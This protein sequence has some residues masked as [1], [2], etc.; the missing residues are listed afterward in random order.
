MGGANGG[1]EKSVVCSRSCLVGVEGLRLFL[2]STRCLEH[3]SVSCFFYPSP[4]HIALVWSP[5][6]LLPAAW[7]VGKGK[8][9]PACCSDTNSQTTTWMMTPRPSDP[10]PLI[11][12]TPRKTHSIHSLPSPPARFELWF[13]Q[14]IDSI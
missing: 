3:C 7:Q 13:L 5:V 12:K 10:L 2:G 4:T 6:S 9:Q 11:W 1:G 14:Q 8:G